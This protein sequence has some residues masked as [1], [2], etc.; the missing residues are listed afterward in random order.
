ME[1]T[2]AFLSDRHVTRYGTRSGRCTV[3]PF[4][5]PTATRQTLKQVATVLGARGNIVLLSRHY[6]ACPSIS[7][8]NCP[9]PWQDPPSPHLIYGSLGPKIFWMTPRLVQQFNKYT[10]TD[11]PHLLQQS[12]SYAMHISMQ[13]C[14]MMPFNPVH[15]RTV[16]GSSSLAMAGI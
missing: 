10:Q 3:M 12:A 6:K 16:F 1:R 2:S 7:P 4:M 5:Q 14:L 15:Y 8:S 11:R 9:F 13:C